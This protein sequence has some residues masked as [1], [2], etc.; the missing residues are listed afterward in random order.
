[1]DWTGCDL[2]ERVPGKVAGK[3]AVKG[4]RILADTIIEDAAMGAPVEEIHESFP[5][6][7]VDTIR[8]LLAFAHSK[9]LVPLATK[10]G[11]SSR[12]RRMQALM[13]L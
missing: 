7:P 2:V 13:F 8:N 9:Q 11:R 5:S 10:T 12:R 4:T 3:P 1:M 6:L